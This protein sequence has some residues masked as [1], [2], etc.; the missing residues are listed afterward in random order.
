[1]VCLSIIYF[2]IKFDTDNGFLSRT[3]CLTFGTISDWVKNMKKY[4]KLVLVQ[5]VH[6]DNGL[7]KQATKSSLTGL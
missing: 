1:M 4:D 5:F 2:G 6:S 7:E 3:F